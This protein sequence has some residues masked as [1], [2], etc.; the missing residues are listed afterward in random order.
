[1]C[2]STTTTSV[3]NKRDAKKHLDRQITE[4]LRVMHDASDAVEVADKKFTDEQLNEVT[5]ITAK[6]RILTDRLD[7]ILLK[8]DYLWMNKSFVL[9]PPDDMDID[10]NKM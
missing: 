4:I 8:I 2:D 7:K 9:H 1:M 10:T 6:M 3:Q 5:D